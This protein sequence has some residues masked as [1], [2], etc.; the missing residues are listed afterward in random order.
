VYP[1]PFD[2]EPAPDL[3]TV[4]ALID[5]LERQAALLT[6]V[7]TGGA[8]FRNKHLQREYKERRRQLVGAL[9][10]HGLA[11]P[12]PW[13]DL[14][15]W[16]GYW[17]VKDLRT[18]HLRRVAIQERVDPTLDM[19]EQQRSGLRVRDPGSGPPTWADLDARVDELI[20]EL[21]GAIS[22]DDL[23]DVGRR[24]REILIACAQLLADPS[25]VP[26][27][28]APPKAADAKAWLELFLAARASGS[29]RDALRRLIRAAWDLAQTVTHGNVDR[30]D[31]FAAAQATVLIVR[32]LQALE[33]EDPEAG[34]SQR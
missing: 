13:Q 22:R 30:V 12:F 14:P 29:H 6:T 9:E 33:G 21:D 17:A 18:W 4:D 5:E 27:G 8:D 26:T 11:Y 16:H 31:A 3:S 19:L 1:D 32:T 28:H 2:G 20:A 23:Q 10:E 24:S 15:Q 25:L 7:A 34:P